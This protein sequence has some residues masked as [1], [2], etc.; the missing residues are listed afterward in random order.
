MRCR[1]TAHCLA[2]GPKECQLGIGNDQASLGAVRQRWALPG[3]ALHRKSPKLFLEI[4]RRIR[5]ELFLTANVPLYVPFGLRCVNIR[6]W[7]GLP[8]QVKQSLH[9]W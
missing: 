9:L 2:R 4:F 6:I 7:V 5:Y 8:W 1:D 3:R